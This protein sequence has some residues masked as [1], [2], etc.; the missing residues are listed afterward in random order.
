LNT[1]TAAAATTNVILD[2][3]A[4]TGYIGGH[5]ITSSDLLLISTDGLTADASFQG[6][7]WRLCS[8]SAHVET[9]GSDIVTITAGGL[10]IENAAAAGSVCYIIRPADVVRLDVGI[11]SVE[12]EYWAAGEANAPV[13]FYMDPAGA[14]AHDFSAL[15]EFIGPMS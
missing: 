12:K 2:G 10:G 7:A 13:A 14:T 6:N 8:I 3:D 15:A 5:Q 9:G 11:A 4:G 1:A